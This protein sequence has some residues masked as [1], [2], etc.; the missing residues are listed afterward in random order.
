MDTRPQGDKFIPQCPSIFRTL[1]T[2]SM[3]IRFK[4]NAVRSTLERPRR[5]ATHKCDGGQPIG[6]TKDGIRPTLRDPGIL[7]FSRDERLN[8][9]HGQE[10]E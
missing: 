3:K 7:L 5:K 10:D 6:Q 1:I 9:L 4:R 8:G 2:N